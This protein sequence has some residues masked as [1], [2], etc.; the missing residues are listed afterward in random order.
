[1]HRIVITIILLALNFSVIAQSDSTQTNKTTFKFGG[2]VK[3]DFL[4]TWY[5]NGDVSAT[6]PMKDIHF[7]TQ[8]PVGDINRNFHQDAH[9][10][11]SRFNFDVNT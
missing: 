1:M 8:I 3:A 10:K 7:P 5:Y 11:E 2:Y 4:N 6:S 9:V